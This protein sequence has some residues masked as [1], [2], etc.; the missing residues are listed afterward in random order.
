MSERAASSPFNPSVTQPAAADV[1][2]LLTRHGYRV[3]GPRR[4]V[5]AAVLKQHRPFTAEQMVAAVHARDP[6]IGRA[7]VYRTL[8][9]LASVDVL[10]RVLRSDGRPAYISGEPGHRHHLVCSDCGSTVAF[11]A[12]PVADLV[13]DLSRDTRFRIDGHLLEVFGI[14][15]GCQHAG[16]EPG[17]AAAEIDTLSQ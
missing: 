11:S 10:K 12:C 15:P 6:D 9:L 1:A 13:R 4:V 17:A 7:T 5:V 8:E 2:A 3:T 14:C 16:H